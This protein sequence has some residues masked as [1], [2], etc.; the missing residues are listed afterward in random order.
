MAILFVVAGCAYA[1]PELSGSFGGG[2]GGFPETDDMLES[3]TYGSTVLSTIPG[4]FTE[5]RV[6]DDFTPTQ[7][8]TITK[9]T[10]WFVTTAALPMALEL[11]YYPD[12]AGAPSSTPGFE[13]SYP[14]VLTNSGFLFGSYPVYTAQMTVSLGIPSGK[15]WYGFH[16]N[17]GSNWYACVGSVVT[18]VQAYRSMTPGYSWQPCGSSIGVCDT[19]KMIEGTV[20]L[21]RDTWA[22]IKAQY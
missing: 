16:R 4:S 12:N 15:R 21:G 10:Q 22:G 13:T 9:F 3:Y 7:S 8:V 1:Q 5:Y 2:G 18:N 6:I 20:A 19:F 11:M 14:V 17:D